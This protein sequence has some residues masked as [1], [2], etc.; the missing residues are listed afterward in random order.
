MSPAPSR[1]ARR[2]RRS[3][4]LTLFATAL[5]AACGGDSG[6]QPEEDGETS[7][8]RV[9]RPGNVRTLAVAGVT[10]RSVELRFTQ[11][12][13]GV[14][15]PASYEVRYRPTPMGN[16]WRSA[17]VAREGTCAYPVRGTAVGATLTCTVE[18]LNPGTSYDF[19]LMPFRPFGTT[20]I[21]GRTS[22]IVSARTSAD[23]GGPSTVSVLNGNGQTGEVGTPL[24]QPL[25]VKVKNSQG[26]GVEGA[27]VTWS[28]SGGG[29]S[30]S[31]ATSRTDDSGYAEVTRVLG[32]V[33][34]QN[35]TSAFVSGLTPVEFTSTAQ[36]G[37]P[38][39]VSVTP[40]EL[41]LEV[42]EDASM[43]A[44]VRDRY[45][46]PVSG[47]SI[48]WASSNPGVAAVDGL[49]RVVGL[50][51]GTAGVTAS[52]GPRGTGVIVGLHQLTAPGNRPRRRPWFLRLSGLEGHI[53]R[54]PRHLLAEVSQHRPGE[55]NAA[56]DYPAED[57]PLV[58]DG[59]FSTVGPWEVGA[60]SA[61]HS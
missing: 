6:S 28:V 11:V 30:V 47:A 37:P 60:G 51:A 29:G 14:N 57:W 9:L 40:S 44:A 1:V 34:G 36:A 38:A 31:S 45:G 8:A 25:R 4:I 56:S 26:Q 39:S 23:T 33:V 20:T 58:V 61:F 17:T 42:G 32:V 41:A 10:A 13:D 46:N 27:T 50:G 16:N 5:V 21:N 12:S 7:E 2:A 18:G 15:Q 52:I 59:K 43:Q 55:F 53:C 19:Q 49:G 22:N 54:H 24:E 48:T 35:R 3:L